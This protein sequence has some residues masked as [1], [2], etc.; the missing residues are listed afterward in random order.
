MKKDGKK[1]EKQKLCFIFSHLLQEN[2]IKFL[3]FDSS[4]HGG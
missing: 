1:K 4:K 3:T 2:P